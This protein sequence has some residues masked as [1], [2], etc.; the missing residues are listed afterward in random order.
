MSVLKTGN[1]ANVLRELSVG[2]KRVSKMVF[3]I[4][5][6]IFS[7]SFNSRQKFLSFSVRMWGGPQHDHIMC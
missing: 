1:A 4:L 7:D 2:L 6:F 3:H 5:S